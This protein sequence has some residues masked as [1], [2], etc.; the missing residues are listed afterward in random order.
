MSCCCHEKI[1]TIVRGN[2]KLHLL[3]CVEFIILVT[4]MMMMLVMINNVDKLS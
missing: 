4:Q 3:S 2:V 1:F